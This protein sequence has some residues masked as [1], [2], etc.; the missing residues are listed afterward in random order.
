MTMTEIGE[1]FNCDRKYI[2]DINNGK[3]FYRE[4]LSY[5]LRLRAKK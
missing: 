1:I 4:N 3:K 2:G 5:P